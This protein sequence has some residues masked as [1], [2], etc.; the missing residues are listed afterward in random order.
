MLLIN[1]FLHTGIYTDLR[2]AIQ[3]HFSYCN[4]RKIQLSCMIACILLYATLNTTRNT[5]SWRLE[6]TVDLPH[7]SPPW[8]CK[9]KPSL[10]E[11]H[12]SA[13]SWFYSSSK[14][15]GNAY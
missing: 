6:Y 13:K 7:Q 2:P 4:K 10:S 9:W 3:E 8:E 14:N 5:T 12:I 1:F 11:G 15:T